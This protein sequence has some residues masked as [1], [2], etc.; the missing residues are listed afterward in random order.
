MSRTTEGPAPQDI[1][2]ELRGGIADDLADYARPKIATVLAH[3]GRPAL[4]TRL[5]VI[6]HHD[7]ARSHP[8]TARVTVDLDGQPIH[9]STDATTP[10]EAVDLLVDRLGRRLERVATHWTGRPARGHHPQPRA[11]V[12]HLAAD[13]TPMSIAD[14]VA[15]MDDAEHDFRLFVEAT[16]GVDSLVHRTDSGLVLVQADGRADEVADVADGVVDGVVPSNEM[17]PVLDAGLAQS[18]LLDAGLS[19]LFY[20]DAGHGRGSVLYVRG[21]VHLGLVDLSASYRWASSG[22][23]LQP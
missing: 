2:V 17:P 20:R 9:V 21:T 11:T 10:R 19:F 3:T 15:G 6:R 12:R 13:G 22:P 8:V 23:V 14:A 18:R 1:V 4:H 7:P 16:R 5:H